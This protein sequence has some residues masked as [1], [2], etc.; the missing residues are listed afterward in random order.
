MLGFAIFGV[1]R[2]GNIRA[3]ALQR[4]GNAKVLYVV[5]V[6]EK[7]VAEF[8]AKFECEGQSDA[9]RV[10]SDP[11]VDA[12]LVC[13]NTMAHADVVRAAVLAG[14]HVFCEKPLA[15]SYQVTDELCK[16]GTH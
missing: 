3:T 8:A 10:L 1:G 16:I 5:D 9:S 7:R 14:K 15:L 6:D 2:I 12:V 11:R 13:T 4:C